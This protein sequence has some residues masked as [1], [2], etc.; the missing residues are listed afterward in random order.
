M[1]GYLSNSIKEFINIDQGAKFFLLGVFFLPSALPISAIFLLLS[2]FISF[3]NKK[4]FSLKDKWDF[5]LF[6]SIGII[7][8]SAINISLI[9]KPPILSNYEIGDVWLNLFNWVPIFFFY[10]GFQFYLKTHKQKL[11]FS[12]FL[13]SG[14]IPVL[15]SML[16][17]KFFIIY[18]P[19]RT[20]Y[21]LIVWFQKPLSNTTDPVS[22]LFS[23]PNYA[24]IWLVLILPFAITLVKLCQRSL[25]EKTILITICLLIVYLTLL[26]GS[27]NGILGIL[28]STIFIS[29]YKKV[30]F[31]FA[32]VLPISS[33]IQSQVN[34]FNKLSSYSNFIPSNIVSKISEI[35]FGFSPRIDIW[36]SAISRIQERP[37]WG[38]GPSTFPYLHNEH[39]T[40]FNVP[41]R[42]IEAQHSHNI[43]LE[44]AHN[45]GIPLSIILMSTIFFLLIKSFNI[46]FIKALPNNK[47]LIEK[48]W[49]TSSTIFFVCHLTDITYYD[50]KIS[51]LMSIFFAGLKCI[52]GYKS[53]DKNQPFNS[54][55]S[56]SNY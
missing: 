55:S 19:F 11:I 2:L 39:N 34:F 56:Y 52:I 6:V 22:G 4:N 12:K 45:F 14:T 16:L 10:W 9:N 38:W 35:Q 5:P 36:K 17:Q 23:N 25:V 26:T 21:G 40:T 49:F 42:F 41:E 53:N 15:I 1:I 47:N 48:A 7:I 30:L 44:L 24:G 46:I 33:L 50:G 3:K 29:G 32:A 8:F 20:F 51:I 54:N 37:F 43:F 28:I 18:G 27:R 31:I 13:L